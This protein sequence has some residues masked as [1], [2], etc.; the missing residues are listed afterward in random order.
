MNGRIL[1]RASLPVAQLIALVVIALGCT[2]AGYGQAAS[3]RYLGTVTVIAGDTLTVKTDAGETHQVQIPSS[4]SLKRIAPGQ[5][6]LSTAETIQLGDLATGDRVLVR[7][8]PNATGATPQALQ[9][10]AIKQADVA[11]KQQ[12]DREE[13]QRNGVGGLVKSVDP[14]AGVITVT[15]GAGPTAKT[16]TVHIASNT[17]L[18]R[19]APGSVRFDEAQASPI[20]AIQAG[21]QLRAR[22]QKNADGTDI[23]AQEVVS[24]SFR[25]IS[26]TVVEV[27]S[28]AST[29]TVKD[30]ITRKPVTIHTGAET[31]MKRLPDMMARMIAARL[32]GTSTGTRTDT[33][34]A[35][36]SGAGTPP[37]NAAGGSQQRT[38]SGA[39]GAGPGGGQWQGAGQGR[40]PGSGGDMQQVLNRAPAIQLGDL[41]KGEAV[42]LVSTQGATDVTAITL[43]AGVE[44]LLEAPAASQNLLANW[45]MGTGGAEA[46][47]Q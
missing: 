29:L 28:A 30:L 12:K 33:G 36:A 40:G 31:Q 1:N 25:N 2:A 11:M 37:Q 21:D 47:A 5:R 41:Q 18:K 32:K 15:S 34:S 8:D 45:S 27:N 35:T 22:G 4:A 43:L 16:V 9:V 19:Y 26:G 38:G 10:V 7:L 3:S 42:M 39:P 13:W 23:Q 6:D 24:G 14:A 17:L 20:G 44:P 46:A